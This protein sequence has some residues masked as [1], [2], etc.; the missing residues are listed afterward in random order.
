MNYQDLP[1]KLLDHP[2][3]Q[4]WTR[5]EVSETELAH[6]GRAYLDFVALLPDLWQKVF[7]ELDLEKE[8][9]SV[10]QEER[11]HIDLWQAWTSKLTP[12]VKYPKLAILLSVL[13]Q[14]TPSELAGA[15][16]AF[17]VQQPAVSES[18]QAGLIAHYGFT[19]PETKYFDEHMGETEEKHIAFGKLV[20]SRCDRGQ[21][22][23]GFKKGSELYYQTLDQF[24]VECSE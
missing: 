8:G 7:T 4:A 9:V 2:F 10:V 6:Y 20:A 1:L 5:G 23:S 21:F 22:E 24:E 18:K 11:E 19:K 16:H 3:Y 15:I 13:K 14:M 12:V 17:E